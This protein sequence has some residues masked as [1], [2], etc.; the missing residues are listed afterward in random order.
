[1]LY[2]RPGRCN[3]GN[4]RR[5]IVCV[6]LHGD[7]NVNFYQGHK[8]I[9]VRDRHYVLPVAIMHFQAESNTAGLSSFQIAQTGGFW[10]SFQSSSYGWQQSPQ[11]S[12]DSEWKISEN[13]PSGLA[14]RHTYL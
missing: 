5:I 3:N 4:W 10:F 9:V 12:G 14:P 7:D 8:I 1:M 11:S 13:F 2:A 6:L